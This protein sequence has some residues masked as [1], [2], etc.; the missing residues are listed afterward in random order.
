MMVVRLG[1]SGRKNRWCR[2]FLL[3]GILAV[4]GCVSAGSG[5]EF[6]DA[7]KSQ[8]PREGAF[9]E[10]NEALLKVTENY[11]GL[12]DLYKKQ[13][14]QV[15]DNDIQTSDK[16]RIQIA[17]AY[18]HMEDYESALF[19]LESVNEHKSGSAEYFL[20][21]SKA[22]LASGE[23]DLALQAVV[24]AYGFDS[25]TPQVFNQ[26][27]RVQA[28]KGN[29][30]AARRHFEK[31]RKELLDDMVVQNNLAMLDILEGNYHNAAKRLLTFFKTGRADDQVKSNLAFSLA[32][33]GRY[34][35]FVS[36]FGA[37]KKEEE[38]LALFQALAGSQAIHEGFQGE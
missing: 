5:Q 29:Y 20:L 11:M 1:K 25:K 34:Q 3:G 17:E 24:T 15:G 26:L 38:R 37:G 21:K 10:H 36:L 22:L 9:E 12:I 18:V 13:M 8:T 14:G 16:Y 31:A 30:Q 2:V 19:H 6:S 35:D 23:R 33:S 4:Q 28:A 32:K 7:E 27:G